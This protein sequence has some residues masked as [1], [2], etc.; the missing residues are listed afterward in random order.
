MTVARTNH[1]APLCVF[2][3]NDGAV[4]R[5]A[6]INMQRRVELAARARSFINERTIR[7]ALLQHSSQVRPNRFVQI[8]EKS[9]RCGAFQTT[10]GTQLQQTCH[11]HD[12]HHLRFKVPDQF[13]GDVVAIGG[14]IWQLHNASYGHPCTILVP[15]TPLRNESTVRK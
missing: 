9:Q 5:I 15:P 6:V 14:D 7:H 12:G 1:H 10:S 13:R 8:T 11:P 4:R 2:L 3:P